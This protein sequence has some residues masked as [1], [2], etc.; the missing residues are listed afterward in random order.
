[1]LNTISRT[2]D[3]A[4]KCAMQK[5]CSGEIEVDAGLALIRAL[6]EEYEV[7]QDSI[8]RW[9]RQCYLITDNRTIVLGGEP[10]P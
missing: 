9:E 4:I 1:M 7:V 10:S 8:K 3:Y 5:V 2:R 6:N